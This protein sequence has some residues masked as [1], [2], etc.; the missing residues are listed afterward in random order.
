MG[1]ENRNERLDRINRAVRVA[2]N[3]EQIGPANWQG[4]IGGV[5]V[6]M[7]GDGAVGEVQLS[8]GA[9]Q[10]TPQVQVIINRTIIHLE[11]FHQDHCSL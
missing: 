1:K 7:G 2:N 11:T 8:L 4:G 6:G 10:A 3:D 5:G 9:A